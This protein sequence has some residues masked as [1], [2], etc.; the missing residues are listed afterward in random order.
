MSTRQKRFSIEETIEI[1]PADNHDD[2]RDG[3]SFL[4]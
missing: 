4:N 3:S 2:N 1:V